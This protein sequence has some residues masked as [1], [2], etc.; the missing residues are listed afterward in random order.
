MS[1]SRAVLQSTIMQMAHEFVAAWNAGDVERACEIYADD[2]SYVSRSGHIR[3]KKN[4][5][6]HYREAYPNPDA[7]GKLGLELIEFRASEAVI[8]N[9]TLA[10]ALFKWEVRTKEGLSGGWALETYEK[11]GNRIFLVQDATIS[12]NP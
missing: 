3:G 12:F 9:I 10:T 11:R 5:V 4:V 6:A 7:M 1:H 8:P 2:A